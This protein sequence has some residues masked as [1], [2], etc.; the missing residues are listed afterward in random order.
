MAD[1]FKNLTPLTEKINQII[2]SLISS[3]AKEAARVSGYNFQGG[4]KRLRPLIFC[5]MTEALGQPLTTARL[6]MSSA[7]E[8]LHMATLLHDDVVDKAET[9]RGQLAAHLAFGVPEAV[10]AGDYLLAKAALLGME[11][12]NV[13]CVKI[14][15]NVVRDLSLG[16]LIQLDVRHQAYLTEEEYF[17]I[18]YCKTAA[19]IEGAAKTAAILA[20]ADEKSIEA[21]ASYGRYFGLAFQ[22]VDDILDYQGELATFG[23][24]VGHDLDEGKITL[25]FIRARNTLAENEAE[26]LCTLARQEK[27]SPVDHSEIRSLVD[28]AGGTALARLKVDELSREAVNALAVFQPS[29]A[30]DL[31]EA[32]AIASIART[33]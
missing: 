16:E 19:L 1:V 3:D 29:P 33:H 20:E 2:V 27:I 25:P 28:R 4:G 6:E 8:F 12:N 11:T 26:R 32:L 7:F 13:E 18:I 24:P 5:L 23:K 10:L 17:K 30:R 9:R 31:L 15:C 14:M 21:A 22:I